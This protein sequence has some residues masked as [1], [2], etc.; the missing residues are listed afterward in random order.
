MRKP[1]MTY[2]RFDIYH[3][4]LTPEQYIACKG[5]FVVRGKTLDEVKNNIDNFVGG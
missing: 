1:I 2:K 4:E 5:K 3:Y